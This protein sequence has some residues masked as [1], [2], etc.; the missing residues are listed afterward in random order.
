MSSVALSPAGMNMARFNFSH[1][2]HESHYDVLRR[3]RKVTAARGSHA[4]T[5]LDTKG[6]EVRTAMLRDGKKILLESG[7][8]IIIE[9]VGDRYTEFEGFKNEKETRI[10]LSY[11]KLCQSVAPGN[12]ILLSDGTI[13]IKV[14]WHLMRFLQDSVE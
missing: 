1:G 13:T 9:A 10:G 6:P 12:T 4:A 8:E 11:S 5:M 3:F 7:Q 14:C 2:S